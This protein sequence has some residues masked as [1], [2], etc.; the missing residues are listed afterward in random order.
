MRSC[1]WDDVLMCVGITV[2]LLAA[3]TVTMYG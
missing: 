2:L 3:V 1:H